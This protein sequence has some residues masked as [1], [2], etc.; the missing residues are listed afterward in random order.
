MRHGPD[1]EWEMLQGSECLGGNISRAVVGGMRLE[2]E[3]HTVAVCD[4]RILRSDFLVD[5]D[6]RFATGDVL[7]QR[8]ELRRVRFDQLLHGRSAVDRHVEFTLLNE[9]A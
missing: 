8:T 3:L 6:E 7:K 5:R 9:G 2:R 1:P 4:D